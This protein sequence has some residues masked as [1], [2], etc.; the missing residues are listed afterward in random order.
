[1]RKS[2]KRLVRLT[3]KPV[4][5]PEVIVYESHALCKVVRTKSEKTRS[6]FAIGF[7]RI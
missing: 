4:R 1:M 3:A 5:S 2:L 7:D 6:L